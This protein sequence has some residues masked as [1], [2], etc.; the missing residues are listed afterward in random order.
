M[1]Y[2]YL[3]TIKIF[4][5]YKFMHRLKSFYLHSY[6]IIIKTRDGWGGAKLFTDVSQ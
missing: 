3:C 5:Q 2:R 6:T 4:S 1:I